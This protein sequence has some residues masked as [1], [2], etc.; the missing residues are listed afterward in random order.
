MSEWY[1]RPCVRRQCVGVHIEGRASYVGA[2]TSNF[3]HVSEPP[4]DGRGWSGVP[5]LQS[6]CLLAD[7]MALGRVRLSIV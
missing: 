4:T 3:M 7:S 6:Q 1:A 2:G 5:G